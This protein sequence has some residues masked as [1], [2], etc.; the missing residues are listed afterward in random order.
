MRDGYIAIQFLASRAIDDTG[1]YPSQI[2][3]L[4]VMGCQLFSYH[5]M[6]ADNISFGTNCGRLQIASKFSI[7]RRLMALVASDM[8]NLH[9]HLQPLLVLMAQHRI[10][11]DWSRLLINLLH[12]DEKYQIIQEC[13]LKDYYLFLYAV[14]EKRATVPTGTVMMQDVGAPS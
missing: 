12:W 4:L 14:G 9:Y 1:A 5:A 10:G 11:I 7:E 6:K 8:T 2:R 13:W 3:D